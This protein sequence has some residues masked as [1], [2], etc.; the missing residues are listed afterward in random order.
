MTT[1][2][3]IA[4]TARHKYVSLTTFRR[5]GV[6]VSTAVWVARDGDALVVTTERQ[7]GK[8]KRVRH[9]PRVEMRACDMRGRVADA[10]PT[11]VGV[12]TIETDPQVRKRAGAALDAKYG[13]SH[14]LIS[15]LGR[16]RRSD[17]A[18]RVILRITAAS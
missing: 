14:R 16:L 12:A 8:V 5:T 9:T 7:S 15:L 6:P 4:E 13:L 10:A 11:V 3:S 2:A 18:D 1:D 17:P